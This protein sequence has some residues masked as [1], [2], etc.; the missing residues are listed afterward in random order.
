[1][2][3]KLATGVIITALVCSLGGT[4]VLASNTA[5]PDD[6]TDVAKVPSE[7]PAQEEVKPNQPLKNNVLKLVADAKAGKVAPP[8]KSQIQPA[9]SNGFSRKTKIVVG[10]GIAVVVVFL[11]VHHAL[12][13]MFDDFHPFRNN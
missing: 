1:M 12:N 10:V 6:K 3:K 9:R 11:V 7:V 13:H 8:A 4:S 5:S 2:L